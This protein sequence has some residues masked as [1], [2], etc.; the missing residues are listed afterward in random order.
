MH[1]GRFII[2]Y[3]FYLSFGETLF[4]S[5]QLRFCRFAWKR[6]LRELC[7]RRVKSASISGN[8]EIL[9]EHSSFVFGEFD[10][11]G[12]VDIDFIYFLSF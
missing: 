7:M 2:S 9:L 6:P 1:V 11:C 4:P 12:C 8:A 3:F 5:A 10:I